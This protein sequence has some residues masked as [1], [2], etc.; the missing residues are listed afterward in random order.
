MWGRVSRG[1]RAGQDHDDIAAVPDLT[2]V[3]VDGDGRADLRRIRVRVRPV[4]AGE[5]TAWVTMCHA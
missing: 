2:C 4:A 1:G 3:G 5:A